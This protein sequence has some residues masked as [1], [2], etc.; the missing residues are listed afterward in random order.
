MTEAAAVLTAATPLL[1]ALLA[2]LQ[3][4][5]ARKVETVRQALQTAS[6]STLAEVQ[7]IHH[8]VNSE[9]QAM[10]DEIRDMHATIK[11]LELALQ[12]AKDRRR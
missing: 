1:L 10:A 3:V 5:A 4:R 11:S 12:Q 2:W 9:R 8:A 7:G 6:A